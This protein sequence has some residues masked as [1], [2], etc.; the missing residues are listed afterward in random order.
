MSRPLIQLG[1]AQLEEM[2]AKSKL[3]SKALHQIENELKY[4]HKSRAVA[5]LADVQAVMNGI[6]PVAVKLV[7]PPLPRLDEPPIRQLD[8]TGRSSTNPT[9]PQPIAQPVQPKPLTQPEQ[10]AISVDDAY[11]LLKAT[12]ASTWESIEQTRRQLVQQTSP[13]RT[14]AM[15]TGK[16]ALLQVDAKRFNAAYETLSR[17]RNV[18]GQ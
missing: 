9:V 2:F 11:K 16:Q 18:G 15:S 3:D 14:G 8:L 4:R 6:A 12:P 1:I 10:M 7:T 5:L 17:H 13:A